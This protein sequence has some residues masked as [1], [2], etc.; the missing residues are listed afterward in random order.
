MEEGM[1]V[2]R[3]FKGM[4]GDGFIP[5]LLCIYYVVFSSEYRSPSQIF[6]HVHIT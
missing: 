6:V 4:M 1:G 5:P 3:G 2:L